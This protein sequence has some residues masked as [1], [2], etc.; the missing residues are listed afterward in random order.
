M[1]PIA[2]TFASPMFWRNA[3]LEP[4]G[5]GRLQ[6]RLAATPPTA[7]MAMKRERDDDSIPT[8]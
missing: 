2:H 1:L 4:E 3:E 6:S 5:D 8:F 7:T